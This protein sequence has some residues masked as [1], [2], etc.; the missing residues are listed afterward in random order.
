MS[1]PFN[2]LLRKGSSKLLSEAST[3]QRQAFDML[4]NSLISTPILKLPNSDKP[5]SV[6]TDACNHQIG[7]A[8]FQKDEDGVRHPVHFSTRTFLPPERNYNARER[9]RLTV[10]WAV[11]FLLPYLEG[12]AFTLYTDYAALKWMFTLTDASKLLASS[13]LRLLEFDF[14][15]K[16]SKG[17]LNTIAYAIS[18]LPTFG[19]TLI[20]PDLSIPCQVFEA[21]PSGQATVNRITKQVDN[22]L[23][24]NV[25]AIHSTMIGI[26]ARC[27]T[28]S[29][30]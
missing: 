8:L 17:V 5:F 9:E 25:I 27:I 15:I 16:Y 20:A 29:N 30:T 14:E 18:R 10:I 13:R 28:R 6:D 26:R 12:R 4:R 1:A 22:N 7:A 24:Q 11:Q 3:E 19:H 21:Y 23:W 2:A